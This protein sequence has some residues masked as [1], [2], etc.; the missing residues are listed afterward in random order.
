MQVYSEKNQ[1]ALRQAKEKEQR[2]AKEHNVKD[3]RIK[4]DRT[5]KDLIEAIK[6]KKH[7]LEI[8]KQICENDRRTVDKKI[9]EYRAKKA[10]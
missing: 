1:S 4:E 2:L 3:L 6:Q 8:S 7:R 10:E 9:E 5:K